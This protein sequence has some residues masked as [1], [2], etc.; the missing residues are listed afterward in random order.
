MR[1]SAP[2]REGSFH[3]RMAIRKVPLW[4]CE[5]AHVEP[6]ARRYACVD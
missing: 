1:K 4:G 5:P 2:E 6:V 3:I